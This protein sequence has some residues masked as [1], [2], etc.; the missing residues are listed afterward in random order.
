MRAGGGRGS[1]NGTAG[2]LDAGVVLARLDR[3]RRGHGRACALLDT[4]ASRRATLHISAVNLAEVLQHGRRYSRDTGV[5]LV[6][7]LQS[8]AV[9]VH[10]PDEE[11]AR[12]VA[13]FAIWHD[14]SLADR[15]AAAT[16]DHLRARLYTTDGVLASAAR[17][18]G[19]PCT[20]L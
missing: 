3:S 12:R 1:A 8:F 6:A 19:I 9:S 5:D 18:H 17:R 4:G 2:V 10:A 14:V 16:A 7:L 13:E 15:F 20:S 11:V